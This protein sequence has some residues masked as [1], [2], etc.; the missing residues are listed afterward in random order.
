MSFEC[1]DLIIKAVCLLPTIEKKKT[2]KT[3]K[4]TFFIFALFVSFF[5][6]SCVLLFFSTFFFAASE[7]PKNESLRDFFFRSKRPQKFTHDAKKDGTT[8]DPVIFPSRTSTFST[9]FIFPVTVV[10]IS[11]RFLYSFVSSTTG[12]VAF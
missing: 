4:T 10:L 3:K 1:R 8:G 5:S 11:S 6:L 9:F 7:N 12:F 2:K